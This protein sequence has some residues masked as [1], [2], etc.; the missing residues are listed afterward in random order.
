VTQLADALLVSLDRVD[1][2]RALELQHELVGL[3]Q[4]GD[5]P[6][7]LVLLEH[8]PVITLGK[9]ARA[10]NVLASEDDLRRRGVTVC[11]V[12]RGGDVTYHGPG[13]LVGYPIFLLGSGLAG[14]RGYVE[15]VEQAL[16]VALAQLGVNAGLRPGYIGAWVEDRKIASIGVAVK[17]RVTFHGF[18]LNVTTD[19]DAFRLMNPCGLAGVVMTSVAR[20]RGDSDDGRVRKAVVGG[21]EQVFGLR[22]HDHLPRSVTDVT[23]GLSSLAIDSA[24]DRE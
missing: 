13:Q 17:R 23:N 12:E 4:Q 1:Y 9:S 16:I 3:R 10:G 15:G 14:V 11:R 6:D 19:L 20:E 24:S 8:P 18:A 2:S 21:F 7:T 22:F 5:L